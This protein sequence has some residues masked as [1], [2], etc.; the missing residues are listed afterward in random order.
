VIDVAPNNGAHAPIA[1][2]KGK[3]SRR[4]VEMSRAG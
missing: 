2:K 3:K 1:V 4:H